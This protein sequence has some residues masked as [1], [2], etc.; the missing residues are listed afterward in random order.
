MELS[1]KAKDFILDTYEY[2]IKNDME[3]WVRQHALQYVGI[4][5]DDDLD[6]LSNLYT[7][8]GPDS[9]PDLADQDGHGVEI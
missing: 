2:L 8:F 3:I 5:N 7:E 1:Q 4:F 9:I 6:K